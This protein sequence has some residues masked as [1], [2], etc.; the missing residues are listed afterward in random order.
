MISLTILGY[1]LFCG[2]DIRTPTYDIAMY[3]MYNMYNNVTLHVKHVIGW[4][5]RTSTTVLSA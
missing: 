3:N 1:R 2:I 5:V 4:N